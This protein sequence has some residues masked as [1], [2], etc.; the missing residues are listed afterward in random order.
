[1]LCCYERAYLQPSPSSIPLV[2]FAVPGTPLQLILKLLTCLEHSKTAAHA[3]RISQSATQSI[4]SDLCY[5]RSTP[6]H[7]YRHQRESPQ[8]SS[9]HEREETPTPPADAHALDSDR[10]PLPTDARQLTRMVAMFW[11]ARA[12]LNAG[13]ELR[14]ARDADNEEAI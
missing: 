4:F 8:P 1:M 11:N 7:P 12:V 10:S 9:E 2:S 14:R 3:G 13:E 5:L 6:S